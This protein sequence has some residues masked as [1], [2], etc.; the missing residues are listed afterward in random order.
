MKRNILA[1]YIIKLSKWFTLVM[2]IIVLFYEDHGLGLQDVFILKSVYSIAAVALAFNLTYA[3]LAILFVFYIIRG[4]A[5]P[6]LKGY[7]NQMTFSEMRATVLSIRNFIIRLIFATMAPF[8]GWLNDSISLAFALQITALII[9]V[10]GLIF[11]ILQWNK[12]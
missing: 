3:G 4:F 12:K 10:P 2:P 5:T 8:I 9:F 11:L 6:I 1:L 7:I